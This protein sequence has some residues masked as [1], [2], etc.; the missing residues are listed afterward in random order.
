MYVE[1]LGCKLAN[2]NLP[3]H[4][5]YEDENVCC[6]LDHDPYDDEIRIEA[7]MKLRE[8][9]RKLIEVITELIK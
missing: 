9:T 4:V 1:C 3:V 5:V 7:E 6:F 8:T 2:K